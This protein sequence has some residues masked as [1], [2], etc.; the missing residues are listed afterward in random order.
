MNQEQFGFSVARI[1]DVN[2]DGEPDWA[3]GAPYSDEGGT[4]KGKV[5]VF[6]GDANPASITPVG[7][8]GELG[9]DN[10]GYLHFRCRRFRQR[11]TWMISSSAPR[12]SIRP[13]RSG[14]FRLRHFRAQRRGQHR[15]G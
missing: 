5:Y 15:S 13:A 11:R 6:Y 7:I 12:P 1:G 2:D 9:G 14:R 10:F 3:V 8:I 4:N